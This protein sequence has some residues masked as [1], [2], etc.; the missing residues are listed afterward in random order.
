VSGDGRP[1]EP[2]A[3]PSPAIPLIAALL[4]AAVQLSLL[5]SAELLPFVDLPQHVAQAS[6][7]AHQDHPSVTA[8]YEVRL[9]P[10]VNVLYLLL[11]A[12]LMRVLDDLMVVR[13]LLVVYVVGLGAAAWA[14][15]RALRTSSWNVLLALLFTVHFALMY[16][17]MSYCLGL[18]ILLWLLARLAGAGRPAG[19]AARPA[20]GGQVRSVLVDAVVWLLLALAHVLLWLFAI[21]A[22]LLRGFFAHH[23]RPPSLAR[24]AATLPS[25]MLVVGWAVTS[26]ADLDRL[27]DREAAAAAGATVTGGAG[28]TVNGGAGTM[29]NG[30]ADTTAAGLE[31]VWHG[32]AAKLGAVGWSLTVASWP[33]TVEWLVLAGVAAAI[34]VAR[35]ADRVA[36]E[37]AVAA[38]TRAARRW[39]IAVALWAVVLYAVLPSSISDRQAATYGLFLLYQRVLIIAPLVVITTL[40]WPRATRWRAL[41][42]ALVAVA[43]LAT[44]W[45]LDRMLVR[46]GTD[47]AGLDASLAAMP[48]GKIVKSLIYT[49]FPDRLRF[50]AFLH[51]VSYYQAR[52][53]GE[54]DQSFALLP[55]APVHYRDPRRPHL[56]RQDEQMYPEAFDWRRVLDYDY[57]LIHDRAGEWERCY[58][59]VPL[60]RRYERPGWLVLDVESARAALD[61]ER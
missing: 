10:Q 17:F 60:P 46:V 30:G 7:L 34:I 27:L 43:H 20:A 18:P 23:R 16:G 32:V 3:E 52:T 25:T 5:W 8:L 48:P 11:A 6:L 1:A 33:G 13:L 53:L 12:P 37:D 47:A 35:V 40:R 26:R 45:N 61:G 50:P 21:G 51:V 19:Y 44:A 55:V 9:F 24:L 29:V 56:S 42:I 59:R 2:G 41:A 4:L 39:M 58:A 28:A 22:L 14:L 38:A 49:P 57:V 36:P 15:T 31:Y 54:V